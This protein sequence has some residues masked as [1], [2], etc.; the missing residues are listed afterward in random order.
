MMGR[1]D[2]EKFPSAMGGFGKDS[3]LTKLYVEKT[4][5]PICIRLLDLFIE[6]G[7]EIEKDRAPRE[8]L[9]CAWM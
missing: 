1:A 5:R 4:G 8:N 9:D 3:F 7:L 2:V 6:R